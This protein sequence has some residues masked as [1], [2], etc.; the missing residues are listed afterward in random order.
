MTLNFLVAPDFSP[1]RFAGW[2]MLNT[3]LQ[4]RS[5]IHLHLLTPASPSEQAELLAAEKA[6]LVYATAVPNIRHGKIAGY[7]SVR[8]KP[9]RTR[10]DE[11]IPVYREW[12]DQEQEQAQ[13]QEKEKTA[14]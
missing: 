1:E 8:R 10:I 7:T 14:P 12:R 2:H 9:S 13:A 11:L 3:V 4:R 6:D 5:G